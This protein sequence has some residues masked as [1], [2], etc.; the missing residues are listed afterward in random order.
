MI[1][2]DAFYWDGLAMGELRV[3][4]CDSCER[5]AFPP[6]PS[7]PHCGHEHGRVVTSSGEATLYT[8]TVCH[9][10]FDPQFADDVPYVVGVVDLPEG[11]RLVARIEGVP[12]DELDAGLPVVARIDGSRLV[13]VPARKGSGS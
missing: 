12:H 8:W 10:A 13:F 1:R 6:M 11:A 5:G 7:C 2:D 4:V 9:V 3:R